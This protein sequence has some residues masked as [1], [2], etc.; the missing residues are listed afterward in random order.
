MTMVVTTD[1]KTVPKGVLK[2]QMLRI[3]REIEATG[4]EI[5]VTDFGKPVLRI[6]PIR[7]K[8][9]VADVFAD[10][11]TKAHHVKL[12][13]QDLLKPLDEAYFEIN[14]GLV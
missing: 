10:V 9:N 6:T 7:K 1:E 14:N 4:E 5:I 3:F 13:E 12:D 11:R 8:L 2:S